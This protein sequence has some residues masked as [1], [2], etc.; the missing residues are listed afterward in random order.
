[1][2]GNINFDSVSNFL[3]D[4]YHPAREDVDVDVVLINKKLPDMQFNALLKANKKRLLYI[5]GTVFNNEDLE[6]TA[7]EKAAACI[8]ICDKFAPDPDDEDA[9]NIMRVIAVKNFSPKTRCIIQLLHYQN[10]AYLI[11]INGWDWTL[12]D[13]ASPSSF[14]RSHNYLFYTGGVL[15]RGQV[16]L[17]RP[18]LP[19]TWLLDDYG[20]PAGR[21]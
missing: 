9:T 3:A 21:L 7:M 10:K 12:H 1:M 5:M 8:V 20:Q 16:G 13:Q 14:Y 18:V 11:N 4:F 19:R 17:V 2:C 15:Q 6:K